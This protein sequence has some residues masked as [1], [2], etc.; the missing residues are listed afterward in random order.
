MKTST[1]RLPALVASLAL[2]LSVVSASPA[3]AASDPTLRLFGTQRH[4][5][6]YRYGGWVYVDLGTYLGVTGAPWEVRVARDS[7]DDP[8]R[9]WQV[10]G[11]GGTRDVPTTLLRG[12]T[13]FRRF[14]RLEVFQHGAVVRRTAADLCPNGYELQRLGPDGPES[15]TFPQ[16]CGWN[17]FTLGAVW[18][19]DRDWA[20]N[21][22]SG[23]LG[24]R[25]KVGR[26]VVRLSIREPFREL[27][28]IAA[29][30]ATATVRLEVV[31]G[32]DCAECGRMTSATGGSVEA[33]AE[34]DLT[35][36]PRTTTPSPETLPD[37]IPLP[38]FGI[39]T[40]SEAGEDLLTFAAN[41]W[42][43]GPSPLI[44]EGYRIEGAARM[45]AYQ[46]FTRDGQV[47]GRARV[48]WLEFDD[49]EGHEHWHFEQFA[50]Y[51][52][53]DG[54]GRLVVRSHKQSFC[55]APTDPID[56]LVGGAQWRPDY[57]GFS[58]CGG[59]TAIW[60]RETMPTG[61][62]D[63]YYQGVA[64]QAF[65]ITD[66]PNGTYVIEVAANPAGLLYERDLANDVTLR[67]VT[68]GGVPGHRTVRVAP[69]HGIRG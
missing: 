37:L 35:V 66:V 45:K 68:L 61:W 55:L 25:L 50:R 10:L 22:G 32:T 42:N 30:D 31:K 7:Y 6:A 53:L 2:L 21:T 19:I 62:G 26:Y 11:D 54:D 38:A 46:S 29:H 52:L 33:I 48:G 5:T 3:Q 65:S 44:V 34:G 18:G 58:Q 59:P 49:R 1:P 27:F 69:Y 24:L 36:A 41:V 51:R 39:A 63:T 8:I 15:P 23:G 40:S 20:A 60:I 64:G 56:L 67:E 47:V 17:A 28:G 14:F 13:G 12:W 57:L 9:A 16:S 43:Q 4:V